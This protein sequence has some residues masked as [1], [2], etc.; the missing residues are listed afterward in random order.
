MIDR[1]QDLRAVALTAA[2]TVSGLAICFFF[3]VIVMVATAQQDVLTRLK[4]EGLSIGYSSALALR[5]EAQDKSRKVPRIRALIAKA[6]ADADSTQSDLEQS[7]HEFDTAWEVF[8]PS[9]A[10]LNRAG[11]CDLSQPA[12][13]TPAARAAI[14]DEVR[15]CQAEPDAP[16]SAARALSSAQV[17]AERFSK[18]SE[19]FFKASGKLSTLKRQEA[20]W[21]AQL[22][23]NLTL[24]DDQQKAGRSFGDIDVLLQPWVLFGP[25]LVKFPPPLLQILLTFVSGL[26]GALLITLILVVYP[27]NKISSSNNARSAARTFLGGSIALC[28]YVVILSGTAVLGSGN[29]SNGAGTN[30]MAFCGIGVLAGMFSDRVAGWLSTQADAFF[31]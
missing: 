24:S 12:T 23:D 10:R 8:A 28:V 19:A 16:A 4:A 30:Y 13:D 26:F 11:L 27:S 1:E 6:S 5:E 21:Q 25:A 31:K 20:Y 22:A 29:T 18:S 3:L 9:V 17:E 15:Q 14:A 2:K 7:Q